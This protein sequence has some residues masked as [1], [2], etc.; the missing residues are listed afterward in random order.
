[1]LNARVFR[2][3][4]GTKVTP[5]LNVSFL[6]SVETGDAASHAQPPSQSQEIERQPIQESVRLSSGTYVN[7]SVVQLLFFNYETWIAK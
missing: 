5:S 1:M 3:S 6:L 7:I 4:H 2:V